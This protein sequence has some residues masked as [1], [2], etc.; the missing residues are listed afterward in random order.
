VVAFLS[1]CC[2]CL[3]NA[4]YVYYNEKRESG[5]LIVFLFLSL[6]VGILTYN[7]NTHT[8]TI[9]VSVFPNRVTFLS[10]LVLHVFFVL[11]CLLSDANAL[12]LEEMRHKKPPK[13]S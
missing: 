3:L 10:E 8:H 4:H 1:V 9:N 6:R 12:C 5:G 2:L 7:T 11:F 13:K